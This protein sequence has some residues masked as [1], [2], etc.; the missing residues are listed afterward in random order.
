MMSLKQVVLIIADPRE[1]RH[2]GDNDG[3]VRDDPRR[4][5]G[6]VVCCCMHA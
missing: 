1:C 5:D 2:D 6:A 3:N 4:D